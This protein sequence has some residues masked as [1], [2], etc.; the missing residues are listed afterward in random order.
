MAD[1]KKGGVGVGA[2]APPADETRRD[3]EEIQVNQTDKTERLKVHNGWLYRSTT[4]AG[5]AMVFVPGD[6]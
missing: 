2:P 6:R 5:V 4:G 3:W 1:E